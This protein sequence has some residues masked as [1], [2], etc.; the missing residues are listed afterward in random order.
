MEASALGPLIR[1]GRKANVLAFGGRALKLYAAAADK[2][3]AFREAA[4]ATAAQALGLPVVEVH[5]LR[6]FGEGWGIVM[7]LVN[8]PTFA[9]Q[10]EARPDLTATYLNEMARIQFQVHQCSGFRFTDLKTR[11]AGNVRRAVELDGPTK[12]RLLEKIFELPDGER[13][14]HGDYHPHNILGHPKQATLIDW[15]D[16]CCGTPAAD[17][18][19]SYILMSQ[20]APELASAYVE[21][22]C[23][24]SGEAAASILE[25][26][27]VLAGARLAEDVPG[28]VARLREMAGAI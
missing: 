11:L 3:L 12:I 14:C 26:L 8:G 17:V 15:L 22:Y 16:A 18:C 10:I 7:T 23:A 27:P 5:G 2:H 13:L 25:W 21:A 4:N 19:R 1:A 24:V 6:Q 28:E 9:D 20:A